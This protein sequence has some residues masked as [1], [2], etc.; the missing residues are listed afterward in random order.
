MSRTTTLKK[1]TNYTFNKITAH[2]HKLCSQSKLNLLNKKSLHP[3]YFWILVSFILFL[4]RL[5]SIF[6]YSTAKS[7]SCW[8]V[9]FFDSVVQNSNRIF[10][11]HFPAET[12]PWRSIILKIFHRLLWT[13]FHFHC[14]NS[15]LLF[16]LLDKLK[17]PKQIPPFLR[18]IE[19]FF[20]CHYECHWK[21]FGRLYECSFHWTWTS[22]SDYHCV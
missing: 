1:I 7:S 19:K 12:T 18:G 2:Y 22:S 20:F 6:F 9:L 14:N 4:F 21:C 3:S 17:T 5:A 15:S 10:F 8:S 16:E 11:L 13:Q